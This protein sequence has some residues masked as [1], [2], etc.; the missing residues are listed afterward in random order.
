M[1]KSLHAHFYDIES[2]SNIFTLSNYK[3]DDDACDIYIL[4]DSGFINLNDMEHCKY[5][6]KI[7]RK[8]NKKFKG[9][10]TLYDLHNVNA[11]THMFNA[12]GVND[13]QPNS[14]YDTFNSYAS[15]PGYKYYTRDTDTDYNIA[16]HPYVISYNGFAYDD[17]MFSIYAS[18]VWQCCDMYDNKF[19]FQ[20]TTAA[21]M[22]Q[23]SN[24]LFSAKYK[25]CMASYLREEEMLR[26]GNIKRNMQLS[27]RHI[28]A[29]KLNDKAGHMA[30]KRI[31]GMLGFQILESDRLSGNNPSVRSLEDIAELIAYNI[32]DCI[33]LRNISYHKN[34]YNSFDLK[35]G[36]L[37]DYPELI[38]KQAPMRNADGSVIY[39]NGQMKYSYKPD[40]SPETVA[41]NRLYID[42]TSAQ[43][44]ARALCPYGHLDDIP[45]VSFLYPAGKKCIENDIPRVNVLEEC[46]MFFYR[47]YPQPEIRAKFDA[48]YEYY[49]YIENRNF[50]DSDEYNDLYRNINVWAN[51]EKTRVTREYVEYL[52]DYDLCSK[53]FNHN[54][55]LFLK[56][57]PW[58]SPVSG[59]KY[60]ASAF[61][62]KNGWKFD[63]IFTDYKLARQTFKT[64]SEFYAHGNWTSPASGRTY[65]AIDFINNMDWK[66]EVQM[67]YPLPTL[68]KISDLPDVNTNMVYYNKDGSASSGY[69][70]FSLGGIHGGEYNK[71]LYD[72]DMDEYSLF[73]SD[74]KLCQKEF[75]NPCDLHKAKTWTSSV[76]HITYKASRF[77]KS[78]ATGKR[79]EWRSADIA[80]PIL[81]KKRTSKDATKKG[82]ELN[83]KYTF[84][85]SALC[86]HEDFC[87]YYPNLLMQLL[88]FWNEGLGYDRYEEI[89]GNKERY[90]K[91]MKDKEHYN[92]SERADF[93]TK[94]EGTKLVLNSA[95][96][97]A[98]TNR[99][100]V[101]RMN[102]M[103]ISMRLIGQLFTWR[104]GQAQTY[105]GAVIIS[106]NT[107]GLYSVMEFEKNKEILE[108]ESA[109][110]NVKIEPEICYLIS[111]DTNNRME[112][113]ENYDI[114]S[115]SGGNLACRT[116]P[117]P[118]KALAHPAIIDWALCEYIRNSHNIH[119]IPECTDNHHANIDFLSQPFNDDVGMQILTNASSEFTDKA[120]YLQMFQNVIASS[121]G[122]QTFNFGINTKTNTTKI[123]QHYN[124]IFAVK[125]DIKYFDCYHLAAVWTKV[126][127]P[128]TKKKREKNNER[129]IQ[130]NA[131]ALTLLRAYDVTESQIP[132]GKEAVIKKITGINLTDT[133]I[134]ENRALDDLSEAEQDTI[135]TM[136][137][138]HVYLGL[139]RNAFDNWRNTLP[140]SETTAASE[141][142]DETE[143][144]E[145]ICI[146]DLINK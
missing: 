68:Y 127:T 100:T 44:A 141:T 4:D 97:A 31:S 136:L 55:Q 27:G 56:S 36:L 46:R 32:S 62:D 23:Y 70:T 3:E 72:Y 92:E 89:F 114:I 133:N 94:R 105:E 111:K 96:G 145:T 38:Y 106:T 91:F 59:I 66:P 63:I 40:I 134:I 80:E 54:M 2:L 119:N 75:P 132:T 7:I 129:P 21:C 6:L 139:L 51:P 131:D 137:D 123:M 18:E 50:N 120:K 116:G 103:I 41:N 121:P 53:H 125:S 5:I 76:S 112:E 113:T 130:H 52:K 64:P 84:T 16:E 57:Q 135:I 65:Q 86:S 107:D 29:M 49:K 108:R 90:G 14:N 144:S 37:K 93:S 83:K 143:I 60:N 98:D 30:L 42:S 99:F 126:V 124:R 115:A 24:I 33:Q 88:A 43:L 47:L 17:T 77:L 85:S 45:A 82:Y 69:V 79:A 122:K 8:R 39:E 146:N 10:I 104:I 142:D 109:S 19:E 81:W 20:S 118:S 28:D 13:S 140:D 9:K 102:N 138:M 35:R 12:F 110:I 128:A 26:A 73:K 95:S 101:I 71:K 15:M 25:N 58:T 34:F 11:N 87:S 117:N 48:I 61:M 22:R 1:K 78:G 74:M 67:F